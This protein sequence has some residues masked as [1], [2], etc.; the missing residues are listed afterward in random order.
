MINRNKC[1]AVAS[2]NSEVKQFQI[3]F[4]CPELGK[5]MVA[6]VLMYVMAFKIPVLNFKSLSYNR[7]PETN[8]YMADEVIPLPSNI[9]TRVSKD[10]NPIFL[11]FLLAVNLPLIISQ[12]YTRSSYFT[13]SNKSIIELFFALF[14]PHFT[15]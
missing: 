7:F 10:S 4:L 15:S 11:P 5:Q 8:V 12:P 14:C 1:I 13:L 2:K 3:H 9:M 6:C